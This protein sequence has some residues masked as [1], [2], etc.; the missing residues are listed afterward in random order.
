MSAT[1]PNEAGYFTCGLSPA[2]SQ[3]FKLG[4][5][6]VQKQRWYCSEQHL[7]DDG[8]VTLIEHMANGNPAAF[9]SGR[10][11]RVEQVREEQR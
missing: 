10:A 2:C 6:S 8:D 7:R 1:H 9:A 3:R 4:Y 11:P 5:W